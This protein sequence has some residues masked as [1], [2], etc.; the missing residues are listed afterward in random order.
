MVAWQWVKELLE[1]ISE[2]QVGNGT[3][4]LF[5]ISFTGSQATIPYIIHPWEHSM[6]LYLSCNSHWLVPT[7]LQQLGPYRYVLLYTVLYCILCL[8]LYTVLYHPYLQPEGWIAKGAAQRDRPNA[9]ERCLWLP[10]NSHEW[11]RSK[12]AKLDVFDLG[13]GQ[14]T[15]PGTPCPTPYE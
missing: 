12:A 9:C 2:F 14:T 7:I 4:I 3:E 13:K 8:V 1:R 6:P 15:T 10:P 11:S 5:S